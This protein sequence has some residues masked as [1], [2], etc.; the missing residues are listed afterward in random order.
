MQE[1]LFT[2]D[3]RPDSGVAGRRARREGEGKRER[4]L[5]SNAS[6][7]GLAKLMAMLF[8]PSAQE[9]RQVAER[10]ELGDRSRGR[11]DARQVARQAMPKRPD[12]QRPRDAQKPC[13]WRRGSPASSRSPVGSALEWALRSPSHRPR[14][15]GVVLGSRANEPDCPP[16]WMMATGG[17]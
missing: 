15:P 7:S 9:K 2:E 12:A 17:L 8:G 13:D 4:R 1:Q 10:E 16:P 11:A 14:P 5:Q 3:D 6:K